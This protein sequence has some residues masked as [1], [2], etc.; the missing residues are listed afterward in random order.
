MS[1]KPSKQGTIAEL[2]GTCHTGCNWYR[3]NSIC[4]LVYSH[5][6]RCSACCHEFWTSLTWVIL[7]QNWYGFTGMCHHVKNLRHTKFVH[8]IQ[9]IHVHWASST[10]KFTYR[11]CEIPS[12]CLLGNVT[13]R[14]GVDSQQL[15]WTYAVQLY[16]LYDK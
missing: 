7:G 14:N 11:T 13:V 4:F 8:R 10:S 9:W 12:R 16:H 15:D 3:S 5:E 2:V 6:Y 1:C